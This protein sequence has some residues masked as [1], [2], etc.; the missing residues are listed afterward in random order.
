VKAISVFPG[1]SDSPGG[2]TKLLTDPVKGLENFTELFKKLTSPN[3]AIRV[4]CQGGPVSSTGHVGGRCP[5]LPVGAKLR[6]FRRATAQPD[7]GP[8][9]LREPS[10]GTEYL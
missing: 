3:G 4:F 9:G 2:L 7:D 1:K 10:T 5:H 6:E 8:L